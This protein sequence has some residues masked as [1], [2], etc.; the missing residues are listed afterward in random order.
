M[1]EEL[2]VI[3]L[4][5]QLPHIHLGMYIAHKGCHLYSGMHIAHKG[6]TWISLERS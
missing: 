6:N 1:L 4:T 5:Q 2:A 3:Q